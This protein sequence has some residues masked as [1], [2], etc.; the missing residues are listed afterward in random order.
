[1]SQK[2]GV[3]QVISQGKTLGLPFNLALAAHERPSILA[4]V[5]GKSRL[6]GT[7]GAAAPMDAGIISSGLSNHGLSGQRH[8]V[9]GPRPVE[10]APRV[11]RMACRV[12]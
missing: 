6:K 9:E 8:G 10:K 2:S 4:R 11:P 5:G 3:K 1:M 7:N 12:S